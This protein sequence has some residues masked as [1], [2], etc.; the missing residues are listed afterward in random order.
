MTPATPANT[1]RM[2]QAVRAAARQR[3]WLWAPGVL[4]ALVV[5]ALAH[6]VAARTAHDDARGRF[7]SLARGAQARLTARLAS[8]VDL[9][10]GAAALFQASDGAVSRLQFHRYVGALGL[11]RHFPEVEA[12]RFAV[13]IDGAARA[14]FIDAV[15]KDRS[16]DPAGYPDF[17][18]TPP[19]LRARYEV[20]TFVEPMAPRRERFGVD[21]ASDPEIGRVLEQARDSGGLSATATAS[22]S[23]SAA[24][25]GTPLSI[26]L[27]QPL[28]HL[29][30]S[31][32]VYRQ[33][34]APGS[35]AGRRAAYLGSVGVS[36]SV[37][38]LVGA[39]QGQL[40]VPGLELALLSSN[41]EAPGAGVR[42]Q[43]GQVHPSAPAGA[44]EA[45]LP[46]DVHDLPWQ[47][48]LTL[49]AAT[50]YNAFDRSLPPAALLAGLCG[51]LLVYALFVRLYWSGRRQGDARLLLDTVLQN[52]DAHVYMKDSE[53]RYTYVNAPCAAEM[54]LRPEQVIGRLD[55]EVLPAALADDYWERDRAV[56]VS[57]RQQAGQFEFVCRDGAV[58]QFWTVK[59]PVRA[60]QSTDAAVHA[61][62]GL[63]T[64]VTELHE[65]KAQ[66]D[67]ANQA[68]SNFLS[69][70]SH[71]IRTPMNS[72]IGMSHLALQKAVDP[73]QR[74]YLEKIHHAGAHLLA[75]I[76]DILDFSKIEAGKLELEVIDFSLPTLMHN[77]TAQ[78]EAAAAARGLALEVALAPGIARQLRGDPVRLEQ[79]LLNFTANAIK[80]SERGVVRVTVRAA[81]D[82]HGA[83]AADTDTDADC[84]LR[85]E[86]SDQGIG[87]TA[88][89][90]GAL[91]E[92]FHQADPSTTRMYGGTGLG[93]AISKQLVELMAGTVGVSSTPGQGSTFWFTARLRK[94]VDFAHG[95]G[96]QPA[97]A[98]LDHIAGA[99]ILVVEDNLFSQQVVQELLAEAGAEVAVAA[100]GKEAIDQMLRRRFDCVLMDLQMPVLDGFE[101]TRMVRADPRLR[102]AVVIALTAN[103]ASAD[104]TRAL[105]AGMDQF[106]TKPISPKRLFSLIANAIDARATAPRGQSEPAAR[107][108][109]GDAVFDQAA[110]AATFNGNPDK[111]RKYALLF[112]D[113][114]D[115]GLRDVADAIGQGDLERLAG[116]GHRLKSAAR[117]VGA[118]DFAATCA[119][120]EQLDQLARGAHAPAPARAG[121]AIA[122]AES[123]LATLTARRTQLARQ[124]QAAYAASA[125]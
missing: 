24:T 12:M 51:T 63:S 2:G 105:A 11:E 9:G 68:K 82:G 91:F 73:R 86:V 79:V 99:R 112:L 59:V 107:P 56:F 34:A 89:E 125:A 124:M 85:F 81:D 52:I 3:L 113:A 72:I 83:A 5:A 35:V 111:M 61:V 20:L 100:N 58:R 71:E 114:S 46:L 26:K 28:L 90:I 108:A 119:Q 48:R 33:G 95:E 101:A 50:M 37:A 96:E 98:L 70:M 110:L 21:L 1:H 64:D 74:D 17:D 62:I 41:G 43:V 36:V 78:L 30:I 69:N 66:A 94:G 67:A 55:R 115:D 22:T 109:A 18:I 6:G 10:R 57:G 19:G 93:L 14:P 118:F 60:T 116:I 31:V 45:V 106:I 49:P 29:G 104:Q 121:A 25:A 8:F 32:P 122:A 53:R 44:F 87:M 27:P 77:L 13:A 75:I 76:N 120:L 42:P 16:L 102:D 117:A 97:P 15:R 4:L 38:A 92:S 39:L 7:D 123:L 47:L 80:F 84:M 54:G 65:L 88:A 40:A 103:A 23:A